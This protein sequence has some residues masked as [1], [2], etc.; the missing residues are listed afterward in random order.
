M[1]GVTE[2]GVN[3]FS[4]TLPLLSVRA[5]ARGREGE[6]KDPQSPFGDFFL[7]RV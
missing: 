5:Y 1:M 2:R 7:R 4:S 6:R 3:F